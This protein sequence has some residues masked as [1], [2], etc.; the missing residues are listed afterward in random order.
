MRQVF[1]MHS[2][3]VELEALTEI[4][5]GCSK[6]ILTILSVGKHMEHLE[7]SDT[8]GGMPTWYTY[9]RNPFSNIY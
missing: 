1:L 3:P 5:G 2:G 7:P 8:A 9:V 6:W 4:P